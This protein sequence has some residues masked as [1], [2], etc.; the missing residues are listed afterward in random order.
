MRH[1]I[2]CATALLLAACSHMNG[3]TGATARAVLSPTVGN[4]ASG[5]LYFTQQ[6]DRVLVS[7]EI[8]GL[9]PDA[10]HGFHIHEKGD[11]SSPDAMSAGGHYNPGKHA[12][13]RYDQ[14]EHH[15]GDLPSLRADAAGVAHVNLV[16]ADFGVGTGEHNVIGRSVVVHRDPDDFTS[17]PAGNSGPRLACGVIQHS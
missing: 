11:C 6:G 17:Q 4:S 13:G 7:G 1:L 16:S 9:K 10:E 12:H 2:A 15:E 5:T 14:R 3:P 8:S